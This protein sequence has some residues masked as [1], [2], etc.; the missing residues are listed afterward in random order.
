MLDV[1]LLAKTLSNSE[2]D[3]CVGK[4]SRSNSNLYNL[5]EYRFPLI[6]ANSC[7]E[8][9]AISAGA[10]LAGKLPIV[11][12]DDTTL[13][14]SMHI[15]DKVL[16]PYNLPFIGFMVHAEQDKKSSQKL[17][18][19][20]LLHHVKTRKLDP[21][22]D[23]KT[24]IEECFDYIEKTKKPIILT[25]RKEDILETPTKDILIH[26]QKLPLIVRKSKGKPPKEAPD[27]IKAITKALHQNTAIFTADP[28]LAK[29]LEDKNVKF[30]DID[31]PDGYM[32]SLAAGYALCKKQPTIVIDSPST[33][34]TSFS[35]MATIGHYKPN[36]LLH[37]I[38]DDQR[39]AVTGNQRAITNSM[40]LASIGQALSYQF[41]YTID[42]PADM[43]KA[44][45]GW[46][47]KPE[48]SLIHIKA[49]PS[50]EQK[51][52]ILVEKAPW[53]KKERLENIQ[54]D[55]DKE[56]EELS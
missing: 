27:I 46:L 17:D 8:S 47:K 54:K 51:A 38:Y 6:Q 23:L 55:D 40:D 45:E 29:E 35:S 3:F 7:A 53:K 52:E 20:L 41:S 26:G 13:L 10:S 30:L 31:V 42:D 11:I 15:F 21:E 33:L 36:Y 28:F 14:S 39:T 4:A 12:I 16:N 24:Q 50:E 43:T 48:T 2:L 18:E 19:D 9:L 34:L 49:E 5:F 56:R 37:I 32:A 22:A 25:L 1:D 44:I